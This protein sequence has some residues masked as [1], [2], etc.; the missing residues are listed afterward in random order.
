MNTLPPEF[1]KPIGRPNQEPFFP[2][3]QPMHEDLNNLIACVAIYMR[4][5]P[6]MYLNYMEKFKQF[7]SCSVFIKPHLP[8]V[9]PRDAVMEMM[10]G[11]KD[12]PNPLMLICHIS[13]HMF[14]FQRIASI[15]NI[16]VDWV[17][18]AVFF[19]YTAFDAE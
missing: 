6:D 9:P 5:F 11:L 19:L 14:D 7:S 15:L 13:S 2:P 10:E 12:H 18:L 17:V 16:H 8:S 3:I 1:F 4:T